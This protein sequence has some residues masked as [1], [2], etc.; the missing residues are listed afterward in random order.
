MNAYRAR[1]PPCDFLVPSNLVTFT[2]EI[3]VT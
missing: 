3:A 1:A 2:R